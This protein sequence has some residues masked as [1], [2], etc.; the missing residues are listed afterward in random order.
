MNILDRETVLDRLAEWQADHVNLKEK[1]KYEGLVELSFYENDLLCTYLQRDA[2]ADLRQELLEQGAIEVDTLEDHVKQVERALERE[3]D[4]R[5]YGATKDY[6]HGEEVSLEECVEG[7][8]QKL[9]EKE[10][11]IRNQHLL[12]TLQEWM[13][14]T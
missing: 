14:W 13:Q 3:W 10:D 4:P 7:L 12:H 5:L 8:I 2:C 9:Q 11:T 6:L 1:F